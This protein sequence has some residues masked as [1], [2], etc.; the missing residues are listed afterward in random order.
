MDN[1]R[2]KLFDKLSLTETLECFELQGPY[3]KR[4]SKFVRTSCPMFGFGLWEAKK[5]TGGSHTD[6]FLQTARKLASLLRW[7][8]KIFDTARCEDW[9]PL[10]WFFSSIGSSWEVSAC[11]ETKNSQREKYRYVSLLFDR[12][13]RG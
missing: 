6:A 3:R 7:Q 10:V 11:Y 4:T 5:T 2:V 12:H 13:V 1:D 9:C 8:R